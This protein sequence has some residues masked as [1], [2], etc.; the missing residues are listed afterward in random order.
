MYDVTLCC[1]TVRNVPFGLWLV[2]H[3]WSRLHT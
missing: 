1:N 2:G 3:P